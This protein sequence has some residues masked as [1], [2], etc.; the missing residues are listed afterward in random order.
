MIPK[1]LNLVVNLEVRVGYDCLL[2][3][4]DR[5]ILGQAEPIDHVLVVE[6]FLQL[7]GAFVNELLLGQFLLGSLD[8]AETEADIRFIPKVKLS[9]VQL[10]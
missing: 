10:A 4:L 9:E 8:A 7:F 2:A 5:L 3:H 1:D 6:V